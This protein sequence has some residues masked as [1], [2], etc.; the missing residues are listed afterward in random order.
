MN[1]VWVVIFKMSLIVWLELSPIDQQG[2]I[3]ALALK[4][5][6]HFQ[7]SEFTIRAVPGK[8]IVN[9]FSKDRE[10]LFILECR[11]RFGGEYEKNVLL[12]DFWKDQIFHRRL[13]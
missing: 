9:Q 8:F 2:I 6:T 7:C 12:S 13:G 3:D 1:S 5:G 11:K 10:L 4:Y